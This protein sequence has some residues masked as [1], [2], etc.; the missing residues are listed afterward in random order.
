MAN[1]HLLGKIRKIKLYGLL[2]SVILEFRCAEWDYKETNY[3]N[4]GHKQIPFDIYLN[5]KKILLEFI[6]NRHNRKTSD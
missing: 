1:V 4:L 6:R 3:N 2:P 5:L